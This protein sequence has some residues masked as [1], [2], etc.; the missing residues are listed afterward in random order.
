MTL[1][2][3]EPALLSKLKQALISPL[4]P[5][6]THGS[7]VP[8]DMNSCFRLLLRG[9]PDRAV[10][11]S[12]SSQVSGQVRYRWDSVAA[13][14]PLAPWG[15]RRAPV[16]GAPGSL[17]QLSP[18]RRASVPLGFVSAPLRGASPF[19][20]TF[21]HLPVLQREGRPVVSGHRG[22]CTKHRPDTRMIF[23]HKDVEIKIT[24]GNSSLELSQ[25]HVTTPP[26]GA[27]PI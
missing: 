21:E 2:G 19:G 1:S 7:Q 15:A 4:G 14:C 12:A 16:A 25:P 3:S 23:S 20:G 10:R 17:S 5:Q 22:M 13:G 27:W 24:F 8:S 18:P 11:L 26:G 6:F 9:L